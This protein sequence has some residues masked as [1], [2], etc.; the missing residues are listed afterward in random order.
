MTEPKPAEKPEPD[1]TA[2]VTPAPETAPERPAEEPADQER[3]PGFGSLFLRYVTTANTVMVTL[4][5]FLLAMVIGAVLIIV[6]DPAVRGTFTYFFSRPTDALSASWTA[7]SDAYAGLFA[8]A[9]VNFTTLAEFQA[10]EATIG[11]LLSPISETLTYAAPLILAGLAVGLAFQAGLFNIGA[12][13]QVIMGTVGAALIGFGLHLP[14][15]LHLP[16]ALLGGAIAGGLFGAIPGVLKAWSGAHEVI[17]SIMLNYVA[18]SALGWIITNEFVKDPDPNKQ[19]A[20]SKPADE[21]S[22]LPRLAGM[23]GIDAPGLRANLGIIVAIAAAA[24]V[25]WLLAKSTLGFRMRAVGLNAHAS[26]TAGMSVPNTYITSMGGAGALAGLAGATLVLGIS[27][28][29]LTHG[30]AGEVGFDGITVALLGRAKPWGVVAAGLLFGALRAGANTMQ[31]TLPLDMVT[32]L[33]AL[34]V[35]FIAAPALVKA[36]LHL[37][38]PAGGLATTTAKGW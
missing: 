3:R 20:I 6:S 10:G 15:Y 7:V 11:R 32:L 13:G 28:H 21:S 34:I 16:L 37:K 4:Y 30:V 12:Q 29:A 24:L 27:P 35:I 17:T 5:S 38:V 25:A 2:P 9:I 26:R 36:M 31:S 19:Y 8:G 33:Q 23:L 18:L 1:D 14:A 22:L